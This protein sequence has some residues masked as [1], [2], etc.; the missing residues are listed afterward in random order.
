MRILGGLRPDLLVNRVLAMASEQADSCTEKQPSGRSPKEL[1]RIAGGK[2]SVWIPKVTGA[3]KCSVS[4]CFLVWNLKEMAVSSGPG[5]APTI[6]IT[7]QYF[8]YM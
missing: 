5:D 4:V 8:R 2:C 1:G 6:P 7:R 3:S